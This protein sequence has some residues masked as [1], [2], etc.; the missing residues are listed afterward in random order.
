MKKSISKILLVL[1][2][3]I[4]VIPSLHVTAVSDDN[5][6]NGDPSR[7]TGEISSK[8]E[9]V[10]AKLSS[11]G[12]RQE[13][14]V[15]NILD[16]EKPGEIVDYG[17]YT[18][19]KNLTD[20]TELE[21][22]NNTVRVTADSKGKFYY[23][24]NM[25][26]EPL[27]WD[28]SISYILD[29]KQINPDELAGKKGHVQIEIRTSANEQ[30]DPVFFEN[31][32]LQISLSLDTD[33]HS[34]IKAPDGMLAN[35]GK[36]KQVTFTVMPEKEEKLTVE[37][38]ALHFELGG[39]DITAIP[40]SMPID[41]PNIDDM[42]G[43]MQILTDAIKDINN[44]V[45][46]LKEGVSELNNGVH[47]LGN[48]S[49]QFKEGMSKIDGSSTELI[50]ASKNIQQALETLNASLS[51]SGSEDMGLG[52]FK[53]LE[54]GLSQ[55]SGGLRETSDGLMTFNE[56]YAKAYNELNKAMEAIPEYEITE[57][58]T[59][60]LYNSGA[61]QQ[62]LNQLLE[63]YAAAR[64]AKGTYSAVKEAFDAVDVTISQINGALTE[65][66][67][68]LD[69]MANG[70]SSS[71][72]QMDVAESF[73]QLQ[74]GINQLASNYGAFHTGLVE[75]SGGVNQLSNSYTKLH[76]GI[77]ELS[78]GTDELENGVGKLHDGTDELYESTSDLPVQMKQE[79]DQM[80][81]DYDKSDF[82]VV[83]FLS[84]KNQQINSVQFVIKTESIK[85]EEQEK[86]EKTTKEKTGFWA[87]LKE[88]FS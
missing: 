27:P 43:D 82:E 54:D 3:T 38:D 10:Y 46:D 16:I 45:G 8:D 77:N 26:G 87:R 76:T 32:L 74:E 84:P 78:N 22:K 24:G 11:T 5:K 75:Y 34:H 70:I 66:A 49:S 71:L 80:I 28:I 72:E 44:G 88:L 56:N 30:V 40:S 35:A 12:E 39:I 23:Q 9:V 33:K 65:M 37:A 67:D 42:T 50:N 55:I 1:T 36:N 47:E 85:K 7:G 31:Y 81:A 48:G 14:Y 17:P 79:V 69:T 25:K 2:T 61:D 73:A 15:V 63:T 51:G 6:S 59:Q 68:N 13:A 4:F 58:K 62:V 18:S 19:L 21:Q 20:L 83:S 41:A 52:D 29:G 64:T 53:K 86:P 60:A 57:E